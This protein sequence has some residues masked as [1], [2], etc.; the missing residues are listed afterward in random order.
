MTKLA[1]AT[2]HFLFAATVAWITYIDRVFHLEMWSL[3]IGTAVAHATYDKTLAAVMA[4]KG[5]KLD[6]TVSELP[7]P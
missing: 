5:R 3:Y 1:A 2:G 7:A 4:F 6:H